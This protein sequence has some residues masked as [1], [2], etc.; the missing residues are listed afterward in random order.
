MEMEDALKPIVSKERTVWM[1]QPKESESAMQRQETAFQVAKGKFDQT[2]N[3]ELVMQ[4]AEAFGRGLFAELIQDKPED[5]TMKEWLNI[6]A[7]DVLN[8]MGTGATITKMTD[9]TIESQMF[10]NTLHET[11]EDQELASVF[12]YGFLRGLLRSAFP[13][14][15]LLM[16]SSVAL[17]APSTSL[18]FKAHA[19]NAD[20]G[21]RER[22][23]T[24]VTTMKT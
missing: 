24:Q 4:T 20:S 18:V 22:V 2:G 10:K 1:T 3:M 15:E 12:T 5:W 11:S 16:N 7:R 19:T 9:D 13:E 21:E 23:K 6:V 8:P 14:G 17:G